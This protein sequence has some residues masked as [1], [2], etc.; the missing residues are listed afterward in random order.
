MGRSI[1]PEKISKAF[2]TLDA[3]DYGDVIQCM[4]CGTCLPTCPTYRTDGIET[5]SPRGRMAMI[6]AVIDGRLPASEEF[7]EHMYH[8]L[9]CRNCQSVCPA[10]VKVGEL[11]LEARHRI[12]ENRPQP[13][14]KRLL[15]HHLIRDQRGMSRLLT[16]LRWLQAA[17]VPSLARKYGIL[18]LIS[19]DLEFME[20]LLP[21]LPAR[22]LSETIPEEIPARGVV[23][24]RVGFFLGCAMNLIFAEVSRATVDVLSGAGYTLIIPKGQQCCGAPNIAEGERK[25][26]REMAEHNM[27]LFAERDVDTIVTDCAACGSELKGY[28]E[29][30][31][32][33]SGLAGMSEQFSGKTQDI[34]E[35]LSAALGPDAVFRPMDEVVC[36]H[37]PCH[38]RHAQKVLRQ[39]RELLRRIPGVVFQDLPDE[40]QCCGSAG[41]YNITHRERSMKI[42]EAKVAAIGRTGARRVITSNPGCLMQLQYA[43]M[44]WRQDWTVSHITEF[45]REALEGGEIARSTFS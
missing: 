6:R 33:R 17:R 29:L 39:P 14:L 25:T 37:D 40:G 35:F 22:P 12:E 3:H 28:R 41:V 44:R 5:Q 15:L 26:C 4:R 8:C 9:D 27:R 7:I 31:R 20:A 2:A 1:D 43:R 13:R 38:S 45:L 32:S 36:F 19:E 30:F 10:G 21:P 23:K 11:V 16:P 42:L 18:K 24:G 34:S